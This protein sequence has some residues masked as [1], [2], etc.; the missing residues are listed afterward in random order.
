ML[1][2][3]RANAKTQAINVAFAK[4]GDDGDTKMPRAKLNTEP[5]A[6]EYHV[7]G[8]LFRIAD[9]RKK[10]AQAAAVKA[11][12]IFDH[13]KNPLV[14]GTAALVYAGE[15]VEIS[16]SVTTPTTRLDPVELGVAMVKAGLALKVVEGLLRRCTHENRASHKFTSTLATS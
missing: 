9:A 3:A 7:A 15:V 11:G 16:V 1:D 10:K 8:H 14:V 13:E 5:V 2:T 4:I 12:V 6:W